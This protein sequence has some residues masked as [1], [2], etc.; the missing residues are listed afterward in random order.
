MRES[1]ALLAT[2]AT[3]AMQGLLVSGD[4][5][6]DEE[7]RVCHVALAEQAFGIAG[8][9]MKSLRVRAPNGETRDA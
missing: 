2:F 9:M 1:E 4:A 3:A 8:E 5:P 7:G 6:R